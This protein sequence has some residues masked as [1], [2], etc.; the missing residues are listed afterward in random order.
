VFVDFS[1][2]TIGLELVPDPDFND[3]ASWDVGAG[4]S[5]IEN[6]QLVVIN[7]SG[8]IFPEPKI[9]TEVGKTYHYALTVTLVNN[10]SGG[11]KVT[12]GAQTIWE[13]GFD[14]GTFTGTVVAT[15]TGGLVF[16]FLTSYIGR[17][18]FDSVSVMTTP[19]PP[20]F[21]LFGSGLLGLVGMARR[22]I[23]DEPGISE[24][25]LF[26]KLEKYDLVGVGKKA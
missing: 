6:G 26:R 22:K 18:E 13:P 11:G 4:S 5:K 19:I 24:R 9:E 17:A 2:I 25:T 23:A 15:G 10:L 20:A 7:H 12:V 14:T 8:F 1:S 16:N 21:W 3:P